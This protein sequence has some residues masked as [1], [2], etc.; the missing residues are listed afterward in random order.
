MNPRAGVWLLFLLPLNLAT[1]AGATV[2]LVPEDHPSITEAVAQSA[3]GDEIRVA[4]GIYSTSTTAE[5]FPIDLVRKDLTIVGAGAGLTVLDAEL[6][7]GLL[8]LSAGNSSVLTGLTLRR[9]HGPAILVED[10]S[11]E[12]VGVH[13]TGN[14]APDGGD[15]VVIRGGQPRIGNSLLVANGTRGPTILVRSGSPVLEH[16]TFHA[17]AGPAIEIHDGAGPVLR[18]NVVSG[19]GAR[20]GESIGIRV[21]AARGG[22]A[23][24]L[25][26]NLFG[27][28]DDGAL[29]IAG[30][31]TALLSAAVRDAE[32]AGGL[33]EG[34]PLFVAPRRLDFRLAEASPARSGEAA[35]LGA[36]GGQH[37]LVWSG[38]APP[39]PA[40]EENEAPGRLGP[41]VPNP[42]TPSTTV[43]FS[44]REHS[45]V[46]LAVYNV[47]GQRIRTLHAGDLSPGDH[48]RVWD[49][50]DDLGADAPPGIYFVRVTEGS[51]TESRRVVLVR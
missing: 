17:N 21:V 4:P 27:G 2:R 12:I 33:R 38:A 8:R 10:A 31:A 49:G 50:R 48:T 16:L 43:H 14:D 41:A 26:R 6:A 30:P 20:G 28:C 18:D 11:P 39:A 9:A 13:F 46:D 25:A 24:I 19:P 32:E 23:P 45:V 5:R 47:L 36:F 42:F 7:S 34:D 40:E 44:I 22:D 51:A 1:P 3:P 37:A 15:A 29:V 35:Q